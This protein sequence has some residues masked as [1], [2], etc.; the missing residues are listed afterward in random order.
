MLNYCFYLIS[1]FYTYID[2]MF[3]DISP[4]YNRNGWLGV[5]HSYWLM[6]NFLLQDNKGKS[7]IVSSIWLS[8]TWN[9]AGQSV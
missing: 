7:F 1:L 6:A 5:K 8:R 9:T 2:G 3:L 4:W